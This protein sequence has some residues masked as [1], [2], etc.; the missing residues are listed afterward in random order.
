MNS[1][2]K[3]KFLCKDRCFKEILE[4]LSEIVSNLN[5]SIEFTDIVTEKD[6]NSDIYLI[7]GKDIINIQKLPSKYIIFQLNSITTNNK[8]EIDQFFG[9]KYI[10]IMKNALSIWDYSIDNINKLKKF[11]NFNNL[12]H[13]PFY[14][15]KFTDYS[16]KISS[17][18]KNI[19]I[20]FNEP[21]EQIPRRK[22]LLDKLKQKYTIY[23][24]TNNIWDSNKINNL[25]KSKLVLNILYNENDIIE[26]K[27]LWFMLNNKAFIISEYNQNS[28]ILS[29]NNLS[30]E[31]MSNYITCTSYD[32]LEFLIDTYLSNIESGQH[33]SD[34]LMTDSKKK[35]NKW[36]S[37][38]FEKSIINFPM[39]KNNINK[40]ITN[41]KK[42]KNL[43]NHLDLLIII[44]LYQYN[45]WRS[46]QIKKKGKLNLNYHIYRMKICHI[47]H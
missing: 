23:T 27:N 3:L 22:E 32:N 7:F 13:I 4:N 15:H 2:T 39:I 24:A 26:F 18:H 14:Y 42:N 46:N 31:T 28:D 19:D 5:I 10:N 16:H 11:Y 44:H 41:N 35:H 47:Y 8:N 6:N 12:Y 30:L 29:D 40:S 9:E 1:N 34:K 38:Y 37:T 25:Y 45:L 20:F 36:K 33:L 43:E 21:H 17:K